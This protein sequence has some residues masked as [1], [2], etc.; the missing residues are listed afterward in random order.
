M[1]LRRALTYVPAL[2]VAVILCLVFWPIPYHIGDWVQFWYGGR[3]V[4]TGGS[5]FDAAAWTP[6]TQTDLYWNG[7]ILNRF[8]GV[9]HFMET[10][11]TLG[12]YPPWVYWLFAPFGLMDL[13]T[14]ITLQHVT[15]ILVG[16]VAV[17]WLVAKLELPDPVRA[18]ALAIGV[19]AQPYVLASRTG[20][21]EAFMLLGALIVWTALERPATRGTIALLVVGAILLAL[22]PH[23][24][25]GFGLIVCAELVRRR[26]WRAIALAAAPL[27]VFVALF[28]LRYPMPLSLT[29][30]AIRT[31]I[32]I[33][34]P[35]TTWALA[36]AL[37]PGYG[38]PLGILLILVGAGVALTTIRIVPER[39]RVG[40]LVALAL[41]VS[42]AVS[43]YTHTWDQQLLAPALLMPLALAS[44]LPGPRRLEIGIAVVFTAFLYPWF[45]YFNDQFGRQAPAGALPF[46]AIGLLFVAAFVTRQRGDPYGQYD[47]V[48][49][50]SPR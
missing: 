30:S 41:C 44:R 24:A 43:P 32:T 3:I 10:P 9:E 13:E 16:L 17:F 4:A 46:M 26:W 45:S 18:L 6:V 49:A 25:I 50:G 28:Y 47:P 20:H 11:N 5:P 19:G 22:K 23:L 33:E 8:A 39:L 12:L 34:D 15:M 31:Q 40:A 35:P 2:L 42:L 36:E 29:G 7:F 27:C 37:A 1:V 14:G 48:W 21:I 38:I